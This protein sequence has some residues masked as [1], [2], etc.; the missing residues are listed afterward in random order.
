ME[1]KKAIT[2]M[3]CEEFGARLNYIPAAGGGV[4][5]SDGFLNLNFIN[6]FSIYR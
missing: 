4:N 3:A 1:R 6:G 5:G 2:F